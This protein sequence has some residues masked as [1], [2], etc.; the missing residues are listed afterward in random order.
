MFGTVDNGAQI[1]FDDFSGFSGNN[2][3]FFPLDSSTEPGDVKDLL[4]TAT[5]PGTS[6]VNTDNNDVG[7]G[8]Q[9]LNNDDTPVD[10]EIIRL[11]YVENVAGDSDDMSTLTYDQH[12]VVNDAGFRAVEFQGNKSIDRSVLIRVYD[13]DDDPQGS[14]FATG[15]AGDPAEQDD[16][17]SARVER[18]ADEIAFSYDG[19]VFDGVAN[20]FTDGGSGLTFTF[21][22]D[23]S[24]QIDGLEEGDQVFVST[25]DGFTQMEVQNVTSGG[26]LGISLDNFLIDMSF[27][28]EVSDEDGDSLVVEDA[29]N[30]TLLPQISGD[31]DANELEGTSF[32]EIFVGGGGADTFVF[33][34]SGD[35]FGD[36]I[37]A[38]FVDA[39]DILS[40]EGVGGAADVTELNSLIA[41]VTNSQDLDDDGNNDDVTVD[42]TDG[43]SITFFDLNTELGGDFTDFNDLTNVRDQKTRGAAKMPRPSFFPAA[44]LH[45][46]ASAVPA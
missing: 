3:V 13:E 21:N 7:S 42:F 41:T 9:W 24:V 15:G 31:G 20:V 18:G 14:D 32:D 6:T 30:V 29:L 19:V 4:V 37:V 39:S 46:R 2:N 33:D 44:R 26:N 10:G 17:T 22:A 35:G 5:I 28:L 43:S 11:D 16:I 25:D 40:F 36:D 12:Y 1:A 34:F 27:D 45:G 23:G 38:D 8:D